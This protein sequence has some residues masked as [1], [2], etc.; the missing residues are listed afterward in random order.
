MNDYEDQSWDSGNVTALSFPLASLITWGGKRVNDRVGEGGDGG[1]GGGRWWQL[2]EIVE[3]KEVEAK[4]RRTLFSSL[5]R[6]LRQKNRNK[7]QVTH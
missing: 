2:F 5:S 6:F 4:G 3:V 1:G 7:R